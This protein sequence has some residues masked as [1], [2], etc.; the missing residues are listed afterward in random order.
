[1][2]FNL[3]KSKPSLKELIPNGFVDIHS[4]VLPGIDDG[5]KNIEESLNLIY[6]MKDLGF[7][8]IIGTPHTYPGLYDNTSYSIKKSFESLKI[9][10]T[11]NIDISYASEYMIDVSLIKMAENRTLLCLKD[12][13]V[14][15]EMSFLSPP[16]KLYEIIFN[17]KINDYIPIMAHPERYLFLHNDFKEYHK[18]KQHGCLFQI[19]IL[20]LY[21]YYGK[22]ILKIANKLLE[23]E[24]IDFVGSDIHNI[25]HIKTLKNERLIVNNK[26]IEKIQRAFMNTNKIF[27]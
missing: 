8:K 2:K 5:A 22:E 6:E 9:R 21:G 13:Y 1:M 3:F 18:L 14:L 19:N 15:T 25:V 17:L 27:E 16:N 10:K 7:Y 12:N 20:S 11:E 24:M 26:N 23:N 4:H